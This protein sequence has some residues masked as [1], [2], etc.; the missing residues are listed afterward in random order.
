M[1]DL[2][3][4]AQANRRLRLDLDADIGDPSADEGDTDRLLDVELAI[5]QASEIVRGYITEPDPYWDAAEDNVPGD[6]SAAVLLVM[7]ALY[8]DQSKGE[9]LKGIAAND[10]ANPVVS[11]LW[12]RHVPTLA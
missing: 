9:M 4:V 1:A 2:V 7:K 8:D 3:T 11:L 6:V 12:K 5:A 10:P